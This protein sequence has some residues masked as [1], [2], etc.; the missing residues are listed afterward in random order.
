MQGVDRAVRSGMRAWGRRAV[1]PLPPAFLHKEADSVYH[2]RSWLNEIGIPDADIR[3]EEQPAGS[4]IRPPDRMDLYLLDKRVIIEVKR[5]GRLS[6]GPY[7]RGT[8]SG[9]YESAHE[10][11]GRYV[12]GERGQERLYSDGGMGEREWIG[13]VT[14]GR[15][16]WVWLWPASLSPGAEPE[17]CVGWAGTVLSRCNKE[18][19][20]RI[21]RRE[22]SPATRRIAWNKEAAGGGGQAGLGRP[23][24]PAAPLRRLDR[25]AAL[26]GDQRHVAR[27]L[28]RR[29]QVQGGLWGRR[30][31]DVR[32][33]DRHADA[34]GR[35]RSRPEIRSQCAPS[36]CG[37]EQAAGRELAAGSSSAHD[38]GRSVR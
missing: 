31:R 16:W 7:E 27:P 10:Q 29:S 15:V 1:T 17:E 12:A 2:V 14:D 6:K 19:L 4:A 23:A 32:R 36:A 22:C 3:A 37:V 25:R 28:R 33:P 26:R 13:A 30:L 34:P 38:G 21:I 35:R 11:V 18:D 9:R 5:Q 24:P 20:A 8:G